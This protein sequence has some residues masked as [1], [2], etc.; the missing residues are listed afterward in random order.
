MAQSQDKLKTVAVQRAISLF[1]KNRGMLRMSQAIEAGVHRNTLYSMLDAGII[2]R[3]TRGLYRL[4]EAAPLGTPDL[5]TVSQKIPR[6]VICLISALSHHELTTQ[7]PHEVHVA[8]ARNS[9][10]PRLEY[11]PIRVFRFSGGSFSEGIEI[12]QMD[13][14]PVRVYSQEKTLADCFKYRNRIGMDTAIEALRLYK[15]RSRVDVESLMRYANICR[16]A[17]VMRPYLEATL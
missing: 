5:V 10:P 14:I 11:P 1:R 9:E 4:A 17:S 12:V 3:M 15:E 8:V 6:S 2:E 7:I 16:V 13:D